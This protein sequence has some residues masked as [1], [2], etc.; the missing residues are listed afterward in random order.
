MHTT[1]TCTCHADGD[2]PWRVRGHETDVMSTKCVGASVTCLLACPPGTTR[3]VGDKGRGC[4]R[5]GSLPGS[6]TLLTAH[7]DWRGTST[8][9][10]ACWP[11]SSFR[12]NPD[13]M[14]LDQL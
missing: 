6:G 10:R 9:A 13:R 12:L 4:S 2:A 3:G 7:R 11:G 8:P 5:R 1:Y 14:G